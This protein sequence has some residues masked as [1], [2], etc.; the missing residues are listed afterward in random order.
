MNESEIAVDTREIVEYAQ[1]MA[2]ASP[3]ITKEL[4]VALRKSAGPIAATAKALAP[5]LSGAKKQISSSTRIGG[6]IKRV[7][8]KAGTTD[9]ASPGKAF[10]GP[11]PLRHPLFGNR[12]FWYS[13]SA[14]PF[15]RPAYAVH[16]A[17][18]QADA[19]AAV[20]RVLYAA[21][22]TSLHHSS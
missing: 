6:G 8:I 16:V 22:Y 7:Y 17:T 1:R 12:K 3:S 13:Q 14:R 20:F 9:G 11:K 10:E 21:G 5:E 4:G 15:L 2:A 19:E 18:V